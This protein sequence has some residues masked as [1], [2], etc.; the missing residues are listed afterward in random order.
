MVREFVEFVL[1]QLQGDAMIITNAISL[2]MFAIGALP[3]QLSL[4][5]IS[6]EVARALVATT[7]FTS[8]VGHADTARLLSSELG[9]EIPM[10]RATITVESGKLLVGQYVGPRLPEGASQ[11][12][13]SARIKWVLVEVSAFI[14]DLRHINRG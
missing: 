14:T 12:P 6:L 1:F 5:E 4:R 7:P 2:N 10:N 9:V 13:E 11:L 3:S 8:A